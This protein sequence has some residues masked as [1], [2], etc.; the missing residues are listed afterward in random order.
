M[1]RPL[2]ELIALPYD[3]QMQLAQSV[4]QS[5]WY[6]SCGEYAFRVAQLFKVEP[7]QVGPLNWTREYGFGPDDGWLQWAP[8]AWSTGGSQELSHE[9]VPT[10]V[11]REGREIAR[12]RVAS[13][14]WKDI[15]EYCPSYLLILPQEEVESIRSW[16]FPQKELLE[17]RASLTQS[18]WRLTDEEKRAFDLDPRFHVGTSAKPF[19]PTVA[20]AEFGAHSLCYLALVGASAP[21]DTLAVEP[22]S[23]ED[24]FYIMN[25]SKALIDSFR[26]SQLTLDRV[27]KYGS[28]YVWIS[29]KYSS[30]QVRAQY[31]WEILTYSPK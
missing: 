8:L 23:G 7:W 16:K 14:A 17:V 5:R 29:T 20:K 6:D 31:D 19:R 10:I 27:R 15:L 25:S 3:L 13:F 22:F 12:K 11:T 30:A 26:S 24:V 28:G 9:C 1:P 18:A 4:K 2:T 21:L